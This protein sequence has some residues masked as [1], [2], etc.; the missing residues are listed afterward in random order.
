MSTPEPAEHRPPGAEKRSTWPDPTQQPAEPPA[1]ESLA[2]AFWALSHAL[3]RL[4]RESVAPL[5]VTPAQARAIGILHRHPGQRI[6]ALSERLRIAARSGTEVIDAL[7]ER[8]LVERTPDPDDRR[9][10]LVTLSSQGEQLAESLRQTQAAWAER[11]F[12][13]LD[14]SDRRELARIIGVLRSS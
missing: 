10:I 6:S 8:G 14:E 7:Q 3:R 2:E 11:F 12:D 13:R 5:G 1:T 4:S 9:A